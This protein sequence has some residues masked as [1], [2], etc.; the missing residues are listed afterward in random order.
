W[1]VSTA[2][3]RSRRRHPSRHQVRVKGFVGRCPTSSEAR[4]RHRLEGLGFEPAEGVWHVAAI[5]ARHPSAVQ[6]AAFRG[7]VGQCAIAIRLRKGAELEIHVSFAPRVSYRRAS[8]FLSHFH[9]D[10]F[11]GLPGMVQSMSMN[12]REAPLEVYGPRGIERLVGEL[13]SLGYFTPGFAVHAKELPP[14][15]EIDCGEYVVRA[16]EAVH[17]VP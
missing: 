15:G 7:K 13:L 3:P 12:G 6:G 16:F 17:T 1:M 4:L 8:K 5:F 11:L 2:G 10:H 14:G 9:G